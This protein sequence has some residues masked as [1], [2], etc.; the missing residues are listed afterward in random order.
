MTS[1]SQRVHVKQLLFHSVLLHFCRAIFMYHLLICLYRDSNSPNCLRVHQELSSGWLSAPPQ[2]KVN[3][4]WQ[5]ANK[6][7]FW[8]CQVQPKCYCSNFCRLI[9]YVTLS[10]LK[11]VAFLYHWEHRVIKNVRR[12]KRQL[13]RCTWLTSLIPFIV[14]NVILC[15]LL[16]ISSL[17]KFFIL[18]N[19]SL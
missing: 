16:F 8:I 5:S 18:F 14:F 17:V 10:T 19:C 9:L 11:C 3:H 2:Q 1:L 4:N 7:K 6:M 15:H 12:L 13:Y